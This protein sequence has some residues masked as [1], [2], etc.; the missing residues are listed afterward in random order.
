MT[1][2]I[3]GHEVMQLMHNRGASL[4]RDELCQLI[5][6]TFGLNARFH[7]CSSEGLDAA[8]LIAF[9]ESKGKLVEKEDGALRLDH[10]CRH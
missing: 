6:D 8:Q 9:L 10:L 3:H 2:S 1:H 4:T 5:A 7:T